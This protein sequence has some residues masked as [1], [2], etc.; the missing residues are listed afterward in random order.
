[1]VGKTQQK[2]KAGF[3]AN[4]SLKKDN[5]ENSFVSY[6]SFVN[7]QVNNMVIPS[8]LLNSPLTSFRKKQQ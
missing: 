7:A 4:Y 3:K 2:L 1:M 6:S 5:H 8:S